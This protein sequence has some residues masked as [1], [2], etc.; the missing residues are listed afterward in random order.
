VNFDNQ[1]KEAEIIVKN[2]EQQLREIRNKKRKFMETFETMC[3]HKYG[4]EFYSGYDRYIECEYCT[5]QVCTH[6]MSF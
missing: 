5:H 4:P 1:I 6:E 2:A 3:V